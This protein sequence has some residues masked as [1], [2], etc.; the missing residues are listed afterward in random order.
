MR[1][2][3]SKWLAGAGLAILVLIIASLA[4]AL[5]K[6]PQTQT[7]LPQDTP[8][9]AVQHYLLAIEE[10]ESR[11]A[12][13]FLSSDLQTKCTFDHFRE[14]TRWQGRSDT[15]DSRDS[16]ITLESERLLDDATE[17]R[18]RIT[19]FYVSAP[20]NVSESS[21]TQ[22]YLLKKLDGNWRFVDKPWPMNYCPELPPVGRP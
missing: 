9:G 2:S 6:R 19:D 21:H 20:F 10:G 16:Q 8:A 7:L 13:D 1:S 22:N 15:T 12:Y 11:R 3:S 14:T 5:L 18:V 4:V 17:V